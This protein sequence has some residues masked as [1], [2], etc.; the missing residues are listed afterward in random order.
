V[1][2]FDTCLLC[3]SRRIGFLTGTEPLDIREVPDFRVSPEKCPGLFLQF[4][5][6]LIRSFFPD[7]GIFIGIGFNFCCVHKKVRKGYL[8]QV[9]KYLYQLGEQIL[10]T[11]AQAFFAKSGYCVVIRTF[12]ALQQP[13]KG[14]IHLAGAFNV[15]A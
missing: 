11:V 12:T 7:K 15:A 1:E 14:Q 9:R 2:G 5:F 8:A 6:T 3:S 10:N 13:P 4:D